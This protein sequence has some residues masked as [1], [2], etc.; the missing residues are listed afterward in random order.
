MKTGRKP[1]LLRPS[2]K[3][4]LWGGNRL[5]DEF[6]KGLDLIPLAET[7]EC[8]THPDGPSYVVGGEFDEQEL[9]QVLREYPEYLGERHRGE[10]T[11]PILI[12]F[13]DA[14]KD[15]SVQ[16]HP[17]DD[18]AQKHEKGQLGKTEMWYVL[19]AS[20]DAKLVYGLK[21]DR[22]EE[23]LRQ[24]IMN[25]T[26]IKEL[27]WVPVKKDDL[28]FIEAGTIH[29]IGAGALVAEIQENSNLTYRLY[30]YDR[31]GK[32]GKKRE[33][34]ID[35]ALKVANLRSSAEPRQPLRVL[36]Y[37]QGVAS[38]LLTRCKYFEVY[39]MIVNTERRQQ[40]H[41]HA[42]EIAFRVLLCVNGCGTISYTD[43]SITFYK[44]DCIFVPADSEVLTI[45]G[46]AQF[47][48][49]RG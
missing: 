30:D 10:N 23:Q 12:K 6:E 17:T 8:S 49:V 36:K 24:A 26:V 7:W 4:Y 39:R 27:Q 3:D 1:L 33:L 34:H 21:H 42:D 31:V 15:L 44:G 47:L 45:H 46:Q 14:K 22:T 41:Y 29:A 32:D 5:N 16:V 9:A 38:E 18:Y 2:G 35:K 28:F 25:G 48:D 40:V 13:I 43:G 11:L 37:R 19:D 20:K